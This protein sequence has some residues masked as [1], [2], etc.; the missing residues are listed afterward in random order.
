MDREGACL[1]W[2][3]LS[4]GGV[5]WREGLGQDTMSPVP[6]QGSWEELS[7]TPPPYTPPHS[8]PSSQILGKSKELVPGL[9]KARAVFTHMCFAVLYSSQVSASLLPRGVLSPRLE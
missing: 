8:T 2:P 9:K 7:H 1:S 6:H 3:R 4:G 5:E